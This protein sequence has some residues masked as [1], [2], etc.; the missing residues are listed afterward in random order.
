MTYLP[1]TKDFVADVR[2]PAEFAV[3]EVPTETQAAAETDKA[4]RRGIWR[5]VFDSIWTARQRQADR[6]IAR[7]LA[8]N[9]GKLTDHAEREIA[10]RLSGEN[11]RL[12]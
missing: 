12:R 7:Y 8:M 3:A 6:E 1:A 5:V 10:R 11:F 4:P 2:A 9:G